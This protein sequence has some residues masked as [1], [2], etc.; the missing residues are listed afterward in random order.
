MLLASVRS[1]DFVTHNTA[2]PQ[3]IYTQPANPSPTT[4]AAILS[5]LPYDLPPSPPPP[6]QHIMQ[7]PAHLIRRH[8]TYNHLTT[9]PPATNTPSAPFACTHHA[10][11]AAYADLP[12][13]VR[14]WPCSLAVEHPR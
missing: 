8:H 2:P 6:M 13:E 9:Y 3:R 12:V 5:H 4:R 11:N 14:V 7:Q 1:F 10:A